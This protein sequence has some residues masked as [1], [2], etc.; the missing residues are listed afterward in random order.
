MAVVHVEAPSRSQV[1]G[2]IPTGCQPASGKLRDTEN[3]AIFRAEYAEFE[4]ERWFALINYSV[5]HFY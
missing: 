3:A 5:F 4:K 1:K 2:F